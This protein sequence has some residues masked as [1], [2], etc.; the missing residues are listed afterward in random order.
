MARKRGSWLVAEEPQLLLVDV[1]ARRL[2]LGRDLQHAHA[3]RRLQAAPQPERARQGPL[4]LAA[5]AAA[6]A[7]ARLRR[8]LQ[9]RRVPA[10]RDA[11]AGRGRADDGERAGVVR[12]GRQGARQQQ[13]P[14]QVVRRRLRGGGLRDDVEGPRHRE[15]RRR[16]VDAARACAYKDFVRCGRERFL[17]G[18][19]SAG[20][21]ASPTRRSTCCIRSH[22]T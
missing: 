12:A 19:K 9:P 10:D 21:S 13:G 8:R 3:A 18:N 16:A 5:A 14:R 7:A 6:G 11:A 2:P 17:A 4:P 1:A 22:E 15:D 20:N